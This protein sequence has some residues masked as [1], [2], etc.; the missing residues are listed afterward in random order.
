M[1]L[2]A[3]SMST[4]IRS[5]YAVAEILSPSSGFRKALGLPAVSLPAKRWM[6][7]RPVESRSRQTWPT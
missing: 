4:S 2:A 1:H 6:L 3:K 7:G 5:G